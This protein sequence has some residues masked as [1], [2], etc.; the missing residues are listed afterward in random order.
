MRTFTQRITGATKWEPYGLLSVLLSGNA[1]S[2]LFWGI[3]LRIC[4]HSLILTTEALIYD[5]WI[6][7]W[8]RCPLPS[9]SLELEETSPASSQPWLASLANIHSWTASILPWSLGPMTFCAPWNVTRPGLEV[10]SWAAST[11]VFGDW[12]W[13]SILHSWKSKGNSAG[14]NELELCNLAWT[15]TRRDLKLVRRYFC[16]RVFKLGFTHLVWPI[17]FPFKHT[18]MYV[19]VHMW[20][21]I[22]SLFFWCAPPLTSSYITRLRGFMGRRRNKSQHFPPDQGDVNTVGYFLRTVYSAKSFI[23]MLSFHLHK[24]NCGAGTTITHSP[25]VIL[26]S[27]S[28]SPNL[29]LGSTNFLCFLLFNYEIESIFPSWYFAPPRFHPPIFFIHFIF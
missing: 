9:L 4:I 10:N 2:N 26:Q 11:C 3:P 21:Y 23:H 8:V 18:D 20:V 28:R 12:E 25:L 7:R 19:F 29:D 1:H 6:E 15:G 16:K 27:I 5:K 14:W 17:S 13:K 22:V 24:Q